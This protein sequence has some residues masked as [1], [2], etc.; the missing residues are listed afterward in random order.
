MQTPW[1]E[2]RRLLPAAFL[3]LAVSHVAAAQSSHDARMHQASPGNRPSSPLVSKVRAA[4]ARFVDINVAAKDGWVRGTPCVSGPNSGAMGVHYILPARI[5][6]GALN[7]SEPEA[8]IYEPLPNGAMRLVGV[9]FIV[10]AADWARLH[11]EGGTPAVEGHLTHYVGEPNRYGLPAFYELH[12][13]AWENNP[14]G[15]F[16]DWNTRVTCEKQP[17]T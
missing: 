14:N 3:A 2:Y 17:V 15:A 5:G 4:T 11:P 1:H 13:W 7:A 10:I 16:A 8:L 6:D 12:V 9:E